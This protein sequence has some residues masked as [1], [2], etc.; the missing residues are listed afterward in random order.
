MDQ[1]RYFKSFSM[2]SSDTIVVDWIL[3]LS[4]SWLM[5]IKLDQYILAFMFIF[6][7][8]FDFDTMN[9]CIDPLIEEL[10]SF[11]RTHCLFFMLIQSYILSNPVVDSIIWKYFSSVIHCLMRLWFI[12]SVEFKSDPCLVAWSIGRETPPVSGQAIITVWSGF[13]HNIIFHF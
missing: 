9:W 11:A 13:Y 2:I 12:I 6:Y 1:T 4:E 3:L 7:E 10:Q 8:R 5:Q